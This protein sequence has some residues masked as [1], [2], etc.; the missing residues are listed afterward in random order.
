MIVILYM[1]A[2]LIPTFIILESIC[3][4][5]NKE[6]KIKE[7]VKSIST[8][9]QALCNRIKGCNQDRKITTKFGCSDNIRSAPVFF[10][11]EN[12]TIS[13]Y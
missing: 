2:F 9:T 8:Y 6:M 12:Q 3:L 7:V 10:L 5:Y 1:D 13:I 11:N 4:N